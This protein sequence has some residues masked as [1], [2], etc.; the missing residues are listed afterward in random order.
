MTTR[1]AVVFI[2]HE[3]AQVLQFDAEHVETQT[4]K[5]HSHHTK[6]H[7]SQVRSEHEFFAHVCDALEGIA[8][9]LAVGPHTG[10]A[11]FQHYVR[12][13]RPALVTQIVDFQAVD[14]PSDKQLVALARQYFLKHDRMAGATTL[15]TKPVAH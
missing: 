15:P 12:K 2:A 14:H 10:L 9:V 7:G 5:S 11:D 3:N 1:H 8:E 13:H 6:Q 4:I